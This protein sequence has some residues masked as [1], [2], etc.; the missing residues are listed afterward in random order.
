MQA[1]VMH[2]PVVA[3]AYPMVP[4]HEVVGVCVEI[5]PDV[6]SIAVGQTVGFGPQRDW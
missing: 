2:A 4:G 5:G 3:Q 6:R 1:V